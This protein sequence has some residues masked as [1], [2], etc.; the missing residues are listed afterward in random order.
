MTPLNTPLFT[1]VVV[2]GGRTKGRSVSA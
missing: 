1:E 2:R